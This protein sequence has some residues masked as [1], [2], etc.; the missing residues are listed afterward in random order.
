[1]LL[2]GEEITRIIY[3]RGKFDPINTMQ[4]V[5]NFKIYALAIPAALV[6]TIV[7][8]GLYVMKDTWSPFFVGIFEV[9]LYGVLC[10]TL[11]G[12][13]GIVALPVA[14]VIYFYFS[15]VILGFL[16]F[17]KIKFITWHEVSATVIRFVLLI[18]FELLLLHYLFGDR[19]LGNFEAAILSSVTFV[20]YLTFSYLFKF[21]EAQLIFQK[22]GL[23]RIL[24]IFKKVNSLIGLII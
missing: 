11:V 22:F 3:E 10:Y 14:Y 17:R 1:L 16:L 20:V 13:I 23:D 18:G 4:V 21:E 7:S 8:Q 12:T 24:H 15:L 9:A 19:Q 6:G 2:F 5:E